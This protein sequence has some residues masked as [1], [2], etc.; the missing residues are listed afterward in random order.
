M[1]HSRGSAAAEL[2]FHQDLIRLSS[3]VLCFT[4]RLVV[5]HLKAQIFKSKSLLLEVLGNV[6]RPIFLVGNIKCYD[7]NLIYYCFYLPSTFLG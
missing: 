1:N 6:F 7:T 3:Q 2:S 5:T 4:H